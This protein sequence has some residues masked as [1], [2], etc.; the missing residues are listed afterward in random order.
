MNTHSYYDK[1]NFILKV[2]K[3]ILEFKT[4]FPIYIYKKT[5]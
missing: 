2:N 1:I 3:E 5:M 4:T